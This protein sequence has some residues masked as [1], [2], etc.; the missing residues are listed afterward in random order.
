ML[1]E[2]EVIRPGTYWYRDEQTGLPRKLVV[3]PELTKY[4]CDQGNK[5]VSFGLPIPVPYEHDFSAHPMTP[6]DKLLNNAG[7]VKEYRLKGDALFSTLDVQDPDVKRKI[8]HSIRWSSPWIS[9][10]TDGDGRSWNNVIS[11]LALTT[12]PRVTKQEPFGSIAAALSLATET[13]VETASKD[14]ATL[15]GASSTGAGFCLS[16]AGRISL[17]K[18][19]KRAVPRYPL[20]FSMWAG[21]I[22][23]AD[24]DV[25]PKKKEKKPPKD[26][27]D[28]TAG[29]SDASTDTDDMFEDGD[30]PPPS[31]GTGDGAA[32]PPPD[33]GGLGGAMDPLADAGGDVKMEELLCDLLQAL[34]VP[35]PDMS[36]EHEFKRHL[37]EAVMSKIKELTSKGMGDIGAP[38]QNQPPTQQPNASQPGGGQNPLIQQEQQPMFMSLEEINK[39]P[40]PTMKNVA[41]SMYA[42]NQ[43]LRAEMDASKKVAEGL[44]DAELKKATAARDARVSLIGKVLPSAKADLDAM[45]KLPSMALSMGEGGAVVDPMAQTLAVLDKAVANIPTLHQLEQSALSVAP[46]PTDANAL[47]R[48]KED[49]LSDDLSRMMGCAPRKKAG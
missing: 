13:K 43:K 42:E 31:S 44:R 40:D 5:M 34:G 23:L 32:M 8:G 41:L 18:G 2:K 27:K 16:R 4:W 35:M 6:K 49:E 39:L 11:H 15:P 38:D 12:R 28:G 24:E 1:I 10:F 7:E 22:K 37:Y 30:T 48:E 21:G 46:H 17:L 47:S 25:P 3:T 36:N 19:T 14:G 20:A 9:S 45:V 33:D 26:G 29:S